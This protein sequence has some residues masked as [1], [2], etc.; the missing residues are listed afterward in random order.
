M[1]ANMIEIQLCQDFL[2]VML[3]KNLIYIRLLENF[4][5]FSY[6][7]YTCSIIERLNVNTI[8]NLSNT[9]CI[10]SLVLCEYLISHQSLQPDYKVCALIIQHLH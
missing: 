5:L 9:T 2:F 3:I 4:M 7:L 10:I 6:G 8:R 1:I